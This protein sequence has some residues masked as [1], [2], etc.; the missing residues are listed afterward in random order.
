MNLLFQSFDLQGLHL[1]N[2][3]VMAP[4]TRSRVGPGDS[5]TAMNAQ[6]YAQRT[7]C[8]LIISEAVVVAPRGRGYLF[9]PGLYTEDQV[10]GW[11][12]VTEA[13]HLT[14]GLI[15]AQLWHVGR[16]S[17]ISLQPDGD[18]PL[19]PTNEAA[20][21]LHT[22]A[23]TESGESG[24]VAV[25]SPRALR[26]EEI[27]PIVHEFVRAAKSALRA[28]FDGLEILAANGY[29]FDQFLNSRINTRTDEYGG[30]SPETRAR[31]LLET[32]D[33]I[34][35]G[36]K[37]VR[38]GV[39]L[40]PFGTFNSMPNDD[41]AEETFFFIAKELDSRDIAYVH[42][43]DEPISIGHL[44]QAIVDNRQDTEEVSAVSRRIPER[45]LR[46]FKER[47][48]GPVILCGALTPE[49][50]EVMLNEGLADLAAF[51]V[52]FIANP[53]LPERMRRGWELTPPKTDLF[54]G[55][56]AEGYI[57]YPRYEEAGSP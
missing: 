18:A 45:F 14:G 13:V 12:L 16:V 28:G 44:N 31:L 38:L 48:G 11:R 25:S 24:E 32:V 27:G 39:R 36:V 54:Y 19:G 15:F 42:F 5:P 29:L 51:G 17:H 22:F 43:N 40:S 20:P 7:S 6:Y 33:A 1:R 35:G 30:Q 4:M 3:I 41:K 21:D 56:G 57:D 47:F 49:T 50:A 46:E 10:A 23:L 53:D 9:T 34:C 37:G 2:R 52:P 55:G 26:A 8:G